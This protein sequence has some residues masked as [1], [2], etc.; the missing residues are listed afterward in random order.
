VKKKKKESVKKSNGFKGDS[1]D[2]A[3]SSWIKG[4]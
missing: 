4:K 1:A 3:N 2:I